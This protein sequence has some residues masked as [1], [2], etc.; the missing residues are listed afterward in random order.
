MKNVMMMAVA[1]TMLVSIA[2]CSCRE[3]FSRNPDSH[4]GLS[5]SQQIDEIC[6]GD[7]WCESHLE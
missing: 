6:H 2:G 3:C 7:I 5:R 1:I 4:S